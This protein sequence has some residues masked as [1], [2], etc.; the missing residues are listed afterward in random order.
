[1]SF[2]NALITVKREVYHCTCMNGKAFHDHISLLRIL[3]PQNFAVFTLCPIFQVF[4]VSEVKNREAF[5]LT[6]LKN[7]RAGT[8]KSTNPSCTRINQEIALLPTLVIANL[9]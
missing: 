8:Q 9:K 6:F 5:V 3:A 4:Q 7:K 2:V 1:M